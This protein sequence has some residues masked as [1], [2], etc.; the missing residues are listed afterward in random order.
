MVKSV[1]RPGPPQEAGACGTRVEG[2]KACILGGVRLRSGVRTSSGESLRASDRV[3][4]AMQSS[5]SWLFGS[6]WPALAALAALVRLAALGAAGLTSR[7]PNR[8]SH[9]AMSR[10]APLS[11]CS[12]RRELAAQGAWPPLCFARPLPGSEL[13]ASGSASC[14]GLRL[15]PLGERLRNGLG[16]GF[17]SSPRASAPASA[18]TW[19]W[20]KLEPCDRAKAK[21]LESGSELWLQQLWLRFP[22][23]TCDPDLGKAVVA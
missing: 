7:G 15:R 16:H 1:M 13:K 9:P 18:E 5:E 23:S 4:R 22:D 10:P 21:E 19:L 8:N 14:V 17:A 6:S 20:R 2:T 3:A 11:A 12:A